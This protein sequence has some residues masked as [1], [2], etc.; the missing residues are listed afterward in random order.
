MAGESYDEAAKRELQEELGINVPLKKVFKL[1]ASPRTGQEF[2]WV[3]RAEIRGNPTP[4]QN[5][6][7]AGAFLPPA[8]VNCW[9]AGRPEDF[10]PG[11]IECWK[12]YQKKTRDSGIV[13]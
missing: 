11:F 5:E 13:I 7:E 8:I 12:A 4:N 3:Y 1:S 10:A 6:I 9:I 2:L